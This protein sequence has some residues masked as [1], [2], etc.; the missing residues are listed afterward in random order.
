MMAS[1]ADS[2]WRLRMTKRGCK[3]TLPRK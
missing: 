1:D 3:F 2:N